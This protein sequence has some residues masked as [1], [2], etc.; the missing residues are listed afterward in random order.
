MRRQCYAAALHRAASLE[1]IVNGW[2]R[3][4]DNNVPEAWAGSGA[5]DSRSQAYSETPITRLLPG[6]MP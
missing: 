3:S 2:M 6:S 4:P 1:E 5:S